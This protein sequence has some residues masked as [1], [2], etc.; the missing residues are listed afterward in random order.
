M[1]VPQP[2]VS[3]TQSEVFTALRTFLLGVVATGTEV[4]QGQDNRVPEP[5]VGNF[6]VMTPIRDVRLATNTDD[7]VDS[8][9]IGSIAGTVMTITEVEQGAIAVGSVMLGV[10]VADGT[11]VTALGSGEGG[12]GTYTVSPAQTVAS[13][14]ITTGHADI[15]QEVQM[16]V[17]LDVHGP[18]AF[19]NA[20]AISTL[21]RDQ[22]GVEVIQGV[23]PAVTPLSADEPRQ[24]PF[25]NGEQQYEWRWVVEATLQVNET[26]T[27]H[28]AQPFF[29]TATVGVT[30]VQATNPL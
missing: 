28:A 3:P 18:V 4:I 15:T 11:V 9:F 12:V 27:V 25:I 21:F 17:Q 7:Y 1:T 23:N 30:N 22:Y 20:K 24:M 10:G 5:R 14:T 26:I 29:D 19:Q 8:I 13:E 2:T 6:V 16:T